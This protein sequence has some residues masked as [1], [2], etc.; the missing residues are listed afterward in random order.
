MSKE[1]F[2]AIA[3]KRYESIKSLSA[4]DNFYDY[5]KEFDAIIREMNREIFEKS[6][7]E[8]PPDRR[9]KKKST[10]ATDASN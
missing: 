6:L 2:L 5:E 8:L 1:E 4:Q 9:K 7:S 3:A 10:P